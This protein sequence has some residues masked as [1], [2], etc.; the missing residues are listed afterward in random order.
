[1]VPTTPVG[2]HPPPSHPGGSNSPQPG[3]FSDAVEVNPDNILP[4]TIRSQFREVLQTHD[5]VF[6]PAIA[7]YNGIAGP[8][9]A[10]VDMGPVQP[11]QCKGRVPQYSRDTLVELQQKFDELEQCQV[12]RHPEDIGVTVEYMYLSQP[13]IPR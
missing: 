7:G 9:Q 2:L 11:P 3:F 5:K 12:F 6:N 4:D 10:S 1:M 8:V 13:F